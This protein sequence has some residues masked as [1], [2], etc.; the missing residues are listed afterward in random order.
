MRGLHRVLVVSVL[1]CVSFPTSAAES[2]E[3]VFTITVVN[4][5]GNVFA[6][7]DVNKPILDML[8]GGVYTFTQSDA[9]NIGHQLA[10]KDGTGAT[11]STGVATT[12][13]LGTSGAQT[14]ITV[15]ADAPDDLRYYCVAH[16][17]GMGN[18]MILLLLFL[19]KQSLAFAVYLFGIGT[20]HTGPGLKKTHVIMLSP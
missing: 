11:Y 20:L 15:A 19:Q 7:D 16:G 1:C 9:S 10:F 18:M 12:G 14:V 5:G 13:T 17:D 2:L 3:Q 4:A 8:R 6:V